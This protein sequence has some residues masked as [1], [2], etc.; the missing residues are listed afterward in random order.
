MLLELENAIIERLSSLGILAH[1]WSGKPEELFM[2]PKS[3]PAVR[4]VLESAD[5]EE[6]HFSKVYGARLRLSLLVF[7]RSLRD[8]GSGAYEIIEKAIRAITG[9]ILAGFDLRLQ[10]LSLMYHDSGEFCYHVRFIGYGKYVVELDEV[11]PLV[12]R[13]TTYEDDEIISDVYSPNP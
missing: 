10:G 12:K 8:K 11:E 7:F 1:A 3:F 4:V 9:A 2:K 6:M 5:F 13:I